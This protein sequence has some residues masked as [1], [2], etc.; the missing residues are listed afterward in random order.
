MSNDLTE[1]LEFLTHLYHS[2]KAYSTINICRSALSST[3][4]PIG[5]SNLGQH[6]IVVRF[7]RAIYNVNPPR[8]RYNST[9]DVD[10]VF[11][12]IES[13]GPNE[14]LNAKYLARKLSILLALSTFMRTCEIAAIVK[15]SVSFDEVGVS[16]SL[17][18]PRKSQ[19]T[20]H[21]QTFHLN[22]LH[23]SL[24]C[25]VSCLGYYIYSTDTV[26]S[27]E[28]SSFLIISPIKPY[29]YASASTIA[30][31]IKSTLHEAGISSNFAAH[32]T[33]GA[34]SSKAFAAGVSIDSILKQGN[35]AHESTF[36]RFYRRDI[37]FSSIGNTVLNS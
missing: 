17:S 31:W 37:P 3:L 22:K 9:W 12:L 36:S 23:D 13:W 15:Q 14:N 4:G 19:R 27:E 1:I 16:F 20:G 21:V 2:G 35:W 10:V 25:P 6:P 5:I 32:S 24:L 34:A 30:R 18:K 28:N 7:M 29:N 11:K 8:P 33:R 26:R